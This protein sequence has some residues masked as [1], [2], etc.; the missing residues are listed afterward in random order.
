MVGILLMS[1]GELAKGVL[2]TLECIFGANENITVLTLAADDDITKFEED[3]NQAITE[4]NTGEG[5]LVLVDVLGGTPSNKSAQ[6]LREK[7]VE[8]LTGLNLPML[9]AAV[10]ARMHNMNL[11]DM[12]KH[13]IEC[14]QQS[15]ISLREHFDL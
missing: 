15:I 13:T 7:D 12:K 5:V 9:L 11:N 4:L 6:K 1:H 3:M 8:V 2:N 14:A 10:E